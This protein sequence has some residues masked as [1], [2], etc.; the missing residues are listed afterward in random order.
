MSCKVSKIIRWL[1][2]KTRAVNGCVP[3]GTTLPGEQ[4]RD[5]A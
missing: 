2:R 3:R 5:P 1:A 4:F